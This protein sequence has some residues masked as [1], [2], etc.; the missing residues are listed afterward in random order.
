MVESRPCEAIR[1]DGSPCSGYATH[2]AEDGR[3]VC[4]AHWR[5]NGRPR[6]A[7]DRVHEHQHTEAHRGGH[8]STVRP[9]VDSVVPASPGTPDGGNGQDEAKPK[10][11]VRSTKAIK[12]GKRQ[13][14]FLNADGER[15]RAVVVHSVT[16]GMAACRG[17]YDKY[18]SSERE[19]QELENKIFS[20]RIG[21]IARDTRV[22]H[23][24]PKPE[25]LGAKLPEAIVI[26]SPAEVAPNTRYAGSAN[27]PLGQTQVTVPAG[28]AERLE[29]RIQMAWRKLDWM[30]AWLDKWNN[31]Q[32][33]INR[34][35]TYGTQIVQGEAVDFETITIRHATFAELAIK[36]MDAQT[37]AEKVLDDLLKQQQ[38]LVITAVSIL[39]R[40]GFKFDHEAGMVML[41]LIEQAQRNTQKVVESNPEL[42]TM[43]RPWPSD[44]EKG[45]SPAQIERDLQERIVPLEVEVERRDG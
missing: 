34:V 38:G 3:N 14:D 15:C 23:P 5:A 40:M 41:A 12:R 35:E 20:K 8:Q 13:C 2:Q 45:K 17:H 36:M 18:R 9:N 6:R 25:V 30:N 42:Y 32:D 19:A 11:K 22:K 39:E 26:K 37:K 1:A 43:Q 7:K 44:W 24:Q 29:A 10:R 21:D 28:F 31:E 27:I 4:F 33:L 16:N